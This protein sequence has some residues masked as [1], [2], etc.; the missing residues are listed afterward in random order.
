MLYAIVLGVPLVSFAQIP[1]GSER[2]LQS[3]SRVRILSPVF[4]DQKQTVTV[5]SSSPESLVYR[6][7]TQSEPQTLST[8]S[9]TG[10]DISAG[11]HS[12]K[13]KGLLI[14]LATGA[15]VG[16]IVGYATWQRPTCK[17]PN[18]GF[19][20]IA[21]DFGRSGDA[22]FAGGLGGIVGAFT[23]LLIGSRQSE[24]WVPVTVPAPPAPG[25]R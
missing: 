16:G 9:I 8:A 5:V 25:A 2:Q 4:G 21:I 3:G 17:D 20:C 6:L 7:T 23:G 10:M 15:V 19:G 18:G 12:N 22:A 13:L 14:G 1:G 24:V 11:S